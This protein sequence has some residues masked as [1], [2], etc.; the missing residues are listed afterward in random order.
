MRVVLC[1]F[2]W[3]N[4][5]SMESVRK[6]TLRI[7]ILLHESYSANAICGIVAQRAQVG[8]FLPSYWFIQLDGDGSR[9]VTADFNM[10]WMRIPIGSLRKNC[11]LLSLSL[12]QKHKVDDSH[13]NQRIVR[14]LTARAVKRTFG[15]DW[16]LLWVNYWFK[17]F[18]F[19][20][21]AD[22]CEHTLNQK[23]SCAKVRSL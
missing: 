21:V 6:N 12:L 7:G 16:G 18:G 3:R 15:V 22:S 1:D 2:Y 23:I 5:R 14:M 11:E 9:I 17:A 10:A 19:I 4:M 20:L 8:L 13:S